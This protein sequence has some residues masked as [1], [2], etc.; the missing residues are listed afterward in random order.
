MKLC[1]SC[2]HYRSGAKGHLCVLHIEE[3]T[4]VVTGHPF[5]TGQADCYA[6]RDAKGR[7][8]PE[9]KLWKSFAVAVKEPPR[10]R[11]PEVA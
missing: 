2:A 10:P 7:C 6:E 8:G 5:R 3:K 9:G 1:K 11:T 4:D